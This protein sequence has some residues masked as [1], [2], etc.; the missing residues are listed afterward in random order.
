MAKQIHQK[1]KQPLFPYK[2]K[3]LTNLLNEI[4]K[5][6]PL[7]EKYLHISNY[8]RVKRLQRITKSSSG[9]SMVLKEQIILPALNKSYN[10]YIKDYIYALQTGVRI[11]GTIFRFQPHRMVYYCF[12]EE[13]DL[14]D[15]DIIIVV[16]GNGFDI[17]PEKLLKVNAKEKSHRMYNI[18]RQPSPFNHA[19]YN[20]KHKQSPT[21]KASDVPVSHYDSNG[22]L[23]CHYKNITEAAAMSNVSIQMIRNSAKWL[24]RMAYGCYWRYGKDPSIDVNIIKEIMEMESVRNLEDAY[25]YY[26]KLIGKKTETDDDKYHRE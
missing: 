8:G 11:D 2:N 4:W 22:K 17:R 18:G 13:F 20:V 1:D 12:I 15:R 23:I 10:S 14:N 21:G 16:E 6:I 5:P 24:V 26:I 25:N 7:L 3:S 19:E 9:R